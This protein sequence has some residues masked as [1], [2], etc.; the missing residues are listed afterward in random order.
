MEKVM[1]DSRMNKKSN[2]MPFDGS[3]M[4]FGSFQIVVDE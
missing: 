2:P 1:K 4:I 3:R